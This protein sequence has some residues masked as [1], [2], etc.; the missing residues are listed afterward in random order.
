MRGCRARV[1]P[2]KAEKQSRGG[3]RS[4]LLCEEETGAGKPKDQGQEDGV[5]EEE[6]DQPTGI[7]QTFH[8]EGFHDY[9]VIA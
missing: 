4:W 9:R 2:G 3:R 8:P 6:G 5:E 7:H 1:S